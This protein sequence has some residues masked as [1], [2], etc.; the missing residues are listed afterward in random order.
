M[1]Y[2]ETINA[3]NVYYNI[4]SGYIVVSLIGTILI[5]LGI[6]FSMIRAAGKLNSDA[7]YTIAALLIVIGIGLQSVN[8]FSIININDVVSICATVPIYDV[9]F[10]SNVSMFDIEAKYIIV[11]KSKDFEDSYKVII[12]DDVGEYNFLNSD[13]NYVNKINGIIDDYSLYE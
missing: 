3:I 13:F 1:D 9:K 12:K 10:D 11:E 7:A 6:A 8:L 5:I 4:N 2:V